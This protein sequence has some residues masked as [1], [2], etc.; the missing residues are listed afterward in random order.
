MISHVFIGT[1]DRERATV[2]YTIVM[3]ALGWRRRFSET[4]RHVSLW[5]PPDASRP[6]LGVGL[7][8]DGGPAEP[9]NGPMVALMAQDRPTVD[10]LFAA[11]LAAG[12]TSEGEPGPRPLYQASFYGAY[13]RDLDGNK[14]CVCCHQAEQEQ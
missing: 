4:V 13:F 8:L 6:L 10:R 12:A 5:Q 9:G 14:L 1:N 7:P 3:E 11:A 2:F